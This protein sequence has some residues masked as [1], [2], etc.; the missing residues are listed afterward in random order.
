MSN[1]QAS[2]GIYDNEER[3]SLGGAAHERARGDTQGGGRA[4]ERKTLFIIMDG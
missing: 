1:R 4:G 2:S 3:F